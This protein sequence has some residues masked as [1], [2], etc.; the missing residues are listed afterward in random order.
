MPVFC[1]FMACYTSYSFCDIYVC[2]KYRYV[3][4]HVMDS[5]FTYRYVVST[6]PC[7]VAI[8]MIAENVTRN[9]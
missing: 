8:A 9:M 7:M 3:T 6:S 5:S 2:V 4:M 1:K